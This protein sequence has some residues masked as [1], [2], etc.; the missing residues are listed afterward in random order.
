MYFSSSTVRGSADSVAVVRCH[1]K[2][3]ELT[4]YFSPLCSVG[5]TE[6][7][8]QRWGSACNNEHGASTAHQKD[9]RETRFSGAGNEDPLI[10]PNSHVL[11]RAR[12]LAAS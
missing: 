6:R 1:R 2:G 12:N 4:E 7:L 8:E 10:P 9:K 3:H 5:G 11:G